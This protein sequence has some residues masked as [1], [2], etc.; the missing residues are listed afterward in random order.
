[1]NAEDFKKALEA[2][3]VDFD[4]EP[5]NLAE[6]LT[7]DITLTKINMALVKFG[8][9][10]G[11]YVLTGF[12]I[13]EGLRRT[14]SIDLQHEAKPVKAEIRIDGPP[15][16]NGELKKFNWGL[17]PPSKLT[18]MREEGNVQTYTIRGFLRAE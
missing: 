8:L 11:K 13:Q 12:G 16:T 4:Q 3:P 9:P 5:V 2:R 15:S 18:F 14:I 1:V 6:Q 7:N 10:K 17:Y